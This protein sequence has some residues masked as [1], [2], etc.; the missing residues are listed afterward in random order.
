MLTLDGSH[1]E[2]GGQLV[3]LAVGLSGVTGIPVRIENIRANRSKPGLAAQHLTAVK[4]AAALCQATLRGAAMGSTELEFTPGRPRGG[5]FAFKV[6]TAGAVTLVLQAALPVALAAA[7]YLERDRPGPVGGLT[8]PISPEPVT[9]T[10]EG[11]TDVRWAPPA[12][13]WDNVFLEHLRQ[14][15]A[16]V[17]LEVERRGFFPKGGGKVKLRVERDGNPLAPLAPLSGGGGGGER[18]G[19]P[20]AD[21]PT[22]DGIAFIGNLPHHVRERMVKAARKELFHEGAMDISIRKEV[23]S[24]AS[25]GGGLVL[26]TDSP[27]LG[28]GEL[29]ARGRRSEDIGGDCARELLSQVSAGAQVDRYCADQLL[30]YLALLGGSYTTTEVSEHTRTAAW[31]IERFL[32]VR[33]GFEPAGD[34]QKIGFGRIP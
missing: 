26:W 21:G 25:P 4:A 14:A 18:D 7:G 12:D 13:H 3:R 5:E 20:T 19:Q 24:S 34:L 27:R 1:G 2:G 29:A 16:R 23:C 8:R 22:I 32:P 30:L 11:G 17:K 33:A 6:G 10:V 9:I 15:G 28:H 31:V